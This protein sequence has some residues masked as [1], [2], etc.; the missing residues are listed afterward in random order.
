MEN[1][2]S[3]F[4]PASAADWKNQLLKELKGEDYESLRWPNENGFTLEPFYNSEHLNHSYTPAFTHSD[5][6]IGVNATGSD[7]KTNAELLNALNCGA[8]AVSV[9]AFKFGHF[10]ERLLKDV[11][12]DYIHASFK[13]GEEDL[14]ALAAYLEKNYPNPL[15]N[16][17]VNAGIIT[18]GQ[19]QNWF[20]MASGFSCFGHAKLIGSD[21]TLYNHC[22]CLPYYEV[23]LALAE[24]VEKLEALKHTKLP[25][26]DFVVEM[27]VGTDYFVEI[28]KLRALRRLWAIVRA[29]YGLQNNLYVKVQ[30]TPSNKSIS[31]HHN[32]LLRTTLEAMAAV[33][34]GCNELVLTENDFLFPEQHPSSKRLAINQ[35]HILKYESYFNKMADV[36][37]GSYYIETLTD[38]LADRAL[39]ALK[40]MEAAGGYLTCKQNGHIQK[41]VRQQA[42]QKAARFG[43]GQEITI[44]VNKYHNSKE[45]LNLSPGFLEDLEHTS[46]PAFSAEK[47]GFVSHVLQYELTKNLNRHAPN[48]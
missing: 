2:F 30:S 7:E 32:N 11:R 27:G 13:A 10:G 33:S 6:Y 21:A 15:F 8:E 17:A 29:E 26:T 9:S 23:A 35:Q 41:E 24:L 18:P 44:G 1:L 3:E 5:W 25:A 46:N 19:Y 12:L 48:I 16:L 36:A 43:Q 40:D 22:N 47:I 39:T 34:G 37:C 28:A 20:T 14:P 45:Q 4:K 38:K 31:D 42:E